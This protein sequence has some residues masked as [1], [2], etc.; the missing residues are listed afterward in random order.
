MSEPISETN[1]WAS[2]TLKNTARLRYWTFAWL[3]TMALAT[4]GPKFIWDFATLPTILGVLAN[5]GIGFGMIMANKHYLLGL[6]EMQQKIFLDSCAITLG[7]GLVCGLSYELLE[8]IKLITYEPEISHLIMLM[9]LT[10]LTTTIAG[11]RRY[12]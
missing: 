3:A 4:F 7:V 5:L 12:R 8:D 6:D 11:H 9:C 10:F 1:K 2:S